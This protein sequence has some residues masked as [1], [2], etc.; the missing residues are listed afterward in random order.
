MRAG[1]EIQC[2]IQ[3]NFQNQMKESLN[4]IYLQHR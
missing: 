4:P 2:R 1:G 3:I